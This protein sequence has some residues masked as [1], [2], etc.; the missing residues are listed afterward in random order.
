MLV[1]Q[2]PSLQKAQ[3]AEIFSNAEI[4]SNAAHLEGR[5]I[6]RESGERGLPPALFMPA[7]RRPVRGN[8]DKRRHLSPSTPRGRVPYMAVRVLLVRGLLSSATATA[9]IRGSD[10]IPLGWLGQQA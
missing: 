3:N 9:H 1:F 4:V 6:E 10:L 5:V 2:H 7:L 8:A